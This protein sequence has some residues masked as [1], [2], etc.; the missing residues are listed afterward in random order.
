MFNLLT[1]HRGDSGIKKRPINCRK[2]GNVPE[3]ENIRS[4]NFKIHLL[5]NKGG[6]RPNAFIRWEMYKLLVEF[7]KPNTQ[8]HSSSVRQWNVHTGKW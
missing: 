4:V 6:W 7:S 3:T 1:S 2:H 8:K 5:G